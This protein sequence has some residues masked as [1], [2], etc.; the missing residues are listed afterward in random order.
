MKTFMVASLPCS[1]RPRGHG[2]TLNSDISVKVK[3]ERRMPVKIGE[4]SERTGASARS[5]RYYEQIGLLRSTR[6]GNG[7]REFDDSAVGIVETIRSL[8]ELGFPTQLIERV[9]PCTGDAGP[10]GQDCGTLIARVSEIRDDM[11]AKARRLAETRDTLTRFLEQATRTE[12]E[13]RSAA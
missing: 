11:D 8:L 4:L 10:A 1:L 6:L 13:S 2:T 12:A 9:L 3:R 7:Y 5:I